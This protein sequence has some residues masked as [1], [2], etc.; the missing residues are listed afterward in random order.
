M[1]FL[2]TLSTFLVAASFGHS[3]AALSLDSEKL[4]GVSTK[5][6]FARD[7]PLGIEGTD[8]AWKKAAQWC[9]DGANSAT[10]TDSAD[11]KRLAKRG[12]PSLCTYIDIGGADG[13]DF[14][15]GWWT[16]G[17]VTCIGVVVTGIT[18][19]NT[20]YHALGHLTADK[21]SIEGSWTKFVG[22][23]N[24]QK[25]TNM[26]GYMRVPDTSSK[27]PGSWEQDDQDLSDSAVAKIKQR[28]TDLVGAEPQIKAG[29]M[30]KTA[31]NDGTMW[32]LADH[33]VAADGVNFD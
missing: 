26:K 13:Y 4:S 8:A 21:N 32:V 29:P 20:K 5:Q 18:E 10:G 22:K 33:V 25:L 12:P 2:N 3:A 6:L 30:T 31:E 7:G 19:T 24:G 17:L 23:V 1:R 28:M 11:S 15:I 27:K 14:P 9:V 16:S